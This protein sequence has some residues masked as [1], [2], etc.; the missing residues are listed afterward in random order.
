MPSWLAHQ[1]LC[2]QGSSIVLQPVHRQL[3][4]ECYTQWGAWLVL[5]LSWPGLSA[6]TG[7]KEQAGREDIIPTPNTTSWQMSG[8]VSFPA[9]MPHGSDSPEPPPPG[10]AHCAIQ[11][12][13][14]AHFPKCC[15]QQEG[16]ASL[17]SFMTPGPAFP[18]AGGGEQWGER[19]HLHAHATPWQWGAGSALLLLNP[20]GQLIYCPWGLDQLYYAS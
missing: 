8:G 4:P 19:H 5:L 13:C 12:R 14:I 3:S 16:R 6:T 18:T 15:N 10:P 7:E 1:C 17:P 11:A 9:L 20:R 2:L